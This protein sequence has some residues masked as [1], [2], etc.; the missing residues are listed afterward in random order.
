M[1]HR[2]KV[3]ALKNPRRFFLPA[4]ESGI[5]EKGQNTQSIPGGKDR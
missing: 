1:E 4:K 5:A 3:H 2:E